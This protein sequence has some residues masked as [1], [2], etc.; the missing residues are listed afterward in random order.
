MVV[1]NDMSFAF[2]ANLNEKDRSEKF[3][4]PNYGE[5]LESKQAM[6]KETLNHALEAF[7]NVDLAQAA[8]DFRKIAN[9]I[10]LIEFIIS[11]KGNYHPKNKLNDLTGKE[12]LQHTKSWLIVDG[13]PADI[14]NDIENHPASY[15][16]SLCAYFIEFFTKKE[17][18]VFDPF[19]GIGSTLAAC[20]ELNRNCWGTELNPKYAEYAQNRIRKFQ[21]SLDPIINLPES[22]SYTYRV[23]N[24][25]ARNVVALWKENS[26]PPIKFVMTS[27]P[28]W[29]MLWESRG[30]V[31]S[32]QKQRVEEG[33]DEKYSE[34]FR[35]I[36][37]INEMSHYLEEMK[38]IF[39]EIKKI[40]QPGGYLMIVLQ[41][42]RP[43][44]GIMRPIAW[45]FASMLSCHFHLRQ[46]FI[47]CQDQKFMG[48]CGY[49]SVYV[50]NVHHH[51]CIVVQNPE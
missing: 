6:L 41:N 28:Y 4:K 45:D 48:I 1:D 30:G 32:S 3:L 34:D 35:D 25:D 42:I 13:K 27:P 7:D 31:K 40:M 16:P 18:W 38:K 8:K 49:P 12:W 37:N 33:F 21:H 22:S 39:I 24:N 36:G 46:E 23:I 20:Y 2:K 29:N 43:K 14:D 11:Q 9:D 44:D 47:W 10:K 15:P 51:Y 19:M 5:I 50:S 17:D 26:F